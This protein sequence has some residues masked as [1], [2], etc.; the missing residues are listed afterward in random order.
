[1]YPD[2][3]SMNDALVKF[4]KENII[5]EIENTH[6][7]DDPDKY[8]ISPCGGLKGE[9]EWYGYMDGIMVTDPYRDQIIFATWF[10]P[11]CNLEFDE[12]FEKVMSAM[13]LMTP[14][15]DFRD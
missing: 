13:T 4:I 11:K 14:N 7:E 6:F 12:Y 3:R 15:D 9:L 8:Y 2:E 10:T 1:M 5:F